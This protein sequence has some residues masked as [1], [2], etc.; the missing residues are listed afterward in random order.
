MI[1]KSPNEQT[2]ETADETSR[3]KDAGDDP[4]NCE[5][6]LEKVGKSKGNVCLSGN[7]E[8]YPRRSERIFLSSSSSL[9]SPTNFGTF[10]MPTVTNKKK[11]KTIGKLKKKVSGMVWRCV[12]LCCVGWC[13]VVCGVVL[14]GVWC[15]VVLCCVIWC[16]VAWYGMNYEKELFGMVYGTRR[17]G[18]VPNGMGRDGME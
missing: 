12:V 17:K 13:C 11:G 9:N 10:D 1:S 3:E 15:C 7:E 18:T 4:E 2:E 6:P 14:C 16:C 8:F 5:K